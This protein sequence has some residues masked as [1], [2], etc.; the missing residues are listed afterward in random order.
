MRHWLSDQA[1]PTAERWAKRVTM[2]DKLLKALTLGNMLA[3]L[4]FARYTSILER[5]WGLSMVATKQLPRQTSYA[6]LT[7]ELLWHGFSEFITFVLPLVR[8]AP[9]RRLASRLRGVL[10]MPTAAPSTSNHCRICDQLP[11]SPHATACGHVFCYYCIASNCAA[12]SQF[13]CPICRVCV[14]FRQLTWAN[15]PNGIL[16]LEET[17]NVDS[18]R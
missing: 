18:F 1:A 2:V 6:Y 8:S 10:S 4:L 13:P 15:P 17:N 5:F 3:F 14:D 11:V 9:A 16:D 12:D 7:R